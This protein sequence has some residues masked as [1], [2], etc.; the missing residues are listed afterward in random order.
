V[1]DIGFWVFRRRFHGPFVRRAMA[2]GQR[3][4]RDFVREIRIEL[5]PSGRLKQASMA[6]WS[7]SLTDKQ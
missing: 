3:F 4:L 5:D 6:S 7:S 2:E 1:K